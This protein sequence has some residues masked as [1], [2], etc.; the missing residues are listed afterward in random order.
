[1]G[2]KRTL[3]A[4]QI[5]QSPLLLSLT[6]A[7]RRRYCCSSRPALGQTLRIA[8]KAKVNGDRLLSG[9]AI[10]VYAIATCVALLITAHEYG[11]T[12]FPSDPT[13]I[14]AAGAVFVVFVLPLLAGFGIGRWWAP[15]LLLW[16]VGAA[17]LADAVEPLQRET[18]GDVEGSLELVALIGGCIHLVLILVGV[19]L[20]KLIRPRLAAKRWTL[21]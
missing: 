3:G 16:L 10:A 17:A 6:V 7:P 20:R 11:A 15:V 5:E 19:G 13:G 8:D 18:S 21:L 12:P 1:M 14:A 9:V 2:P 4:L